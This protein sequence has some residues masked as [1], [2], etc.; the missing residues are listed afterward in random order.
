M[1]ECQRCLQSMDVVLQTD[2]ELAVVSSDEAAGSL[3]QSL[4]PVVV[5]H[6]TLSIADLV[7]DEL[8]LALPLAPMHQTGP[9]AEAAESGESEQRGDGENPFSVLKGLK[10]EP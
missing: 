2:S 8:I 7:E 10:R 5:E 9:C 4:D 1:V 3:P 6:G